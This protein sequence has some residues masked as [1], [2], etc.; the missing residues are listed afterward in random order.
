MGKKIVLFT[1]AFMC[2]FTAFLWAQNLKKDGEVSFASLKKALQGREFEREDVLSASD[3]GYLFVIAREPKTKK[4]FWHLYDP[5]SRKMLKNGSCPFVEYTSAAVNASGG[6]AFVYGRYPTAV[7]ALDTAAGKWSQEYEN[8]RKAGL[9]V[10]PISK[11][12]PL[13]AGFWSLLDLWNDEHAVKDTFLISFEG[14]PFKMERI[15]SLNALK[16]EALKQVAPKKDRAFQTG[17]MRLAPDRSIAFVVDNGQKREARREILFFRG[18]DGKISKLEEVTGK[19][20][21]PLDISGG[22]VLY[23]VGGARN[24]QNTEVVLKKGSAGTVVFQ[25]GN[26]LAARIL[27]D[28]NFAVYTSEPAGNYVYFGKPGALRRL[29]SV[30]A[31]SPVGFLTGAGKFFTVDRNGISYYSFPKEP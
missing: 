5:F 12:S 20:I 24:Q 10:I 27:G 31:Q 16:N 9:A 6:G 11:L 23:A 2:L 28:G 3:R 25:K 30:P 13:G 8:P 18:S 14:A 15:V 26:A 17:M 29:T 4:L 7:W 22:A 1:T 21:L 19:K